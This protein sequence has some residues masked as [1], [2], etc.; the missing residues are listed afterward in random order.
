MKIRRK[1]YFVIKQTTIWR[2]FGSLSISLTRNLED[3]SEKAVL[4]SARVNASNFIRTKTINVIKLYEFRLISRFLTGSRFYFLALLKGRPPLPTNTHWSYLFFFHTDL[5]KAI[6]AHLV[7]SFNRP[8]NH[9][10]TAFP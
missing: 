3:T 10:A 2:R 4:G 5:L 6:A 1:T 8:I 9:L 7:M